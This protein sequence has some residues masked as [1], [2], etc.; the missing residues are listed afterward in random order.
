MNRLFTNT[1]IID[2][3]SITEYIESGYILIEDET[4]EKIGAGSAL[5]IVADETIDLNGKTVLPGM[6]NAHTHLYSALA[7]GMPPPKNIPTNFVEK[8]QEIWWKLDLALDINSTKASFEAGLLECLKYGVTT[9]FDHHSSPNFTDGSLELLVNISE[10][11]GQNISVAFETT[12]RN[13]KDKFESGLKENIDSINKFKDNPFIHPLLG[14]HASFTLSGE[15]LKTIYSQIIELPIWGIHIHVAE[16]K[17]DEKDAKSEG[18]ESV[19]DRLNK[20]ELIN[21]HSFIIHGIHSSEKD[22][23]L[24]KNAG[25]TLVHNP[26]SN[27]NNR[28][29]ILSNS[30]ISTMNAGLGTDG[31]RANMLEEAQ[32]GTII[33]SSHLQGGETTI[34]Y[35]ELLFKNNPDIASRAFGRKI[36]HLSPGNHADLAIYDYQPCTAITKD[37][38]AGHILFGFGQPTDVLSRGKYRIKNR[39][40]IDVSE[41]NIKTDAQKQSLRLWNK[42][43]SI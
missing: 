7:M 19:I 35:L 27:A 42:M 14:M 36:G 41:Q 16:D 43:Q 38:F 28:V 2:P 5:N 29:G 3:F 40:F 6:I 15:S 8:L 25:A 22:M 39:K 23:K 13:G 9:V 17:A 37:N 20:F 33:R 32:Q 30:H 21:E 31:M 18:Y 4:I 11:F 12:D 26:T 10:E 1:R 24:L 34:N